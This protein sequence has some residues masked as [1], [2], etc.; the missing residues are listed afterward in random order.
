MVKTHPEM[1][2]QDPQACAEFVSEQYFM[3]ITS[4]SGVTLSNYCVRFTCLI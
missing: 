2:K 1:N 3:S 4:L